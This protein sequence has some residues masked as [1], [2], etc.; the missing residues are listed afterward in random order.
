MPVSQAVKIFLADII[1]IY[2]S[3]LTIVCLYNWVG[4]LYLDAKMPNDSN[5]RLLNNLKEGVYILQ[6]DDFTLQFKNSAA[7]RLDDKL[8]KRCNIS[9]CS[10]GNFESKKKIYQRIDAQVIKNGDYESIIR[11][12][13]TDS[14]ELCLEEIIVQQVSFTSEVKGLYMI[15]TVADVERG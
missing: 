8:Q 15:P 4:F 14:Q 13:N 10:D 5:Q 9:F 11:M 7:N 1:F 6:E 12:L 2:A 3:L